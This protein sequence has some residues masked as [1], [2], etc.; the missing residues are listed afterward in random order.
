MLPLIVLNPGGFAVT[1]VRSL[2]G[3]PNEEGRQEPI[4][5]KTTAQAGSVD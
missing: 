3:S 1:A 2:L 5:E 4:G